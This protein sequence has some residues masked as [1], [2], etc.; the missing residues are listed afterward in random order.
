MIAN[1][2]RT[3]IDS[4][5]INRLPGIGQ[6]NPSR[7]TEFKSKPVNGWVSLIV[8]SNDNVI[9]L[10]KDAEIPADI[11]DISDHAGQ[12]NG[13]VNWRAY[14]Q[15]G[16]LLHLGYRY[17]ANLYSNLDQFNTSEHALSGGFSRWLN[18]SMLG[19]AAVDLSTL[20]LDGNTLLD[21]TIVTMRLTKDL[22][23]DSSLGFQYRY[24]IL[25]YAHPSLSGNRGRDGTDHHIDAYYNEKRT[26][27]STRNGF[28]I[29]SRNTDG[30][31]F[32]SISYGFR[33]QG[34]RSLPEI[35]LKSRSYTPTLSLHLILS[36]TDYDAINSFS[37]VP[38]DDDTVL[39]AISI[40]SKISDKLSAEIRID[41]R[42][43]SSNI[44]FF[45]YDQTQLSIGVSATF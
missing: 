7:N 21:T 2:D 6:N 8:T 34:S 39:A 44:P 35:R 20:K 43:N 37:T 38:R 29:S 33:I 19:S 22:N 16:Q 24:V 4:M 1:S 12:I 45:S 41:H 32:D 25:D 9:S 36:R 42:D 3:A 10:A 17:N 14:D 5:V 11:D 40:G 26:E 28:Q 15:G 27:W 18:S 31:D 13:G 30:S 23:M